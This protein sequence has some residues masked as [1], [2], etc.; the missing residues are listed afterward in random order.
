MIWG[1]RHSHRRCCGARHGSAGKPQVERSLAE[2]FE[3]HHYEILESPDRH[4]RE[5]GFFPGAHV[6]V[7]RNVPDEHGLV[8]GLGRSRYVL[9]RAA[10]AAIRVA[11]RGGCRR[12]GGGGPPP[13]GP[14]FAGGQTT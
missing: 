6:R 1:F 12:C 3:G 13:F 14:P 4:L 9:G 11:D 10:A 5:M 8:V 2:G 7:I